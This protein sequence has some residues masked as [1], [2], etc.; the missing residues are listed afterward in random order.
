MCKATSKV[1]V[2]TLDF[3]QQES[4]FTSQFIR[5]GEVICGDCVQLA[6]FVKSEEN[7]PILEILLS[8]TNLR[9][10]NS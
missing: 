10:K 6:D 2:K 9:F 3:E 4:V 8:D 7:V 1:L 5:Q